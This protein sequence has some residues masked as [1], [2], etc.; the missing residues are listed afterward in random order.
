M[1]FVGFGLR[2]SNF[3]RIYSD[4]RTLYDSSK[5]Q[6]YAVMAGTNAIERQLW[7]EEGLTIVSVPQHNRLP[8]IL[9]RLADCC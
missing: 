2:D 7:H 9:K 3:R 4:A 5:R 1:L 8:A 6:A